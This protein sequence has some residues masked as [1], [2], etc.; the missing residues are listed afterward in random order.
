MMYMVRKGSNKAQKCIYGVET[1]VDYLKSMCLQVSPSVSFKFSNMSICFS[2]IMMYMVRKR[3][4][5]GSKKYLWCGHSWTFVDIHGH[6]WTFH[7]K[8]M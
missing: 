6:S 3:S 4:K 2:S 1:L 8:H 5:K 7:G